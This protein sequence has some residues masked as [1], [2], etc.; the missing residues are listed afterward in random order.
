MQSLVI[1]P[2]GSDWIRIRKD[3]DPATQDPVWIRIW[4]DPKILDLVHPIFHKL[5]ITVM[6]MQNVSG[7]WFS[8]FC[9]TRD[10]SAHAH[11]QASL[12]L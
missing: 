6:H 4:P 1:N 8:C 9:L 5:C 2:V 7:D 11:I 3:P 10:S 12:G